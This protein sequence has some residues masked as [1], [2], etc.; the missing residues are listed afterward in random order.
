MLFAS[1]V[2]QI[3]IDCN[4]HHFFIYPHANCDMPLARANPPEP[5]LVPHGQLSPCKSIGDMSAAES[6]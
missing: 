4:E 1:P 2:M 5:V 3:R 6:I